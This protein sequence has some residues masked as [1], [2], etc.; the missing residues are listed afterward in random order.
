MK[1]YKL[2]VVLAIG[3]LVLLGCSSQPGTV[4]GTVTH[5]QSGEPVAEAEIVVFELE[6]AEKVPQLDAYTKGDAHL[7]QT[8]DENGAYSISLE[9]GSYI[10]EVWAQDHEV[11]NHMVRVKSNQVTTVDFSVTVP[12]P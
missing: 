11:G 1:T 4:E 10:I 8:T 9:K 5:A 12:T 3:T 2:F 6:A 7:K